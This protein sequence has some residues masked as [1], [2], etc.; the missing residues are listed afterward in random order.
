MARFSSF[1]KATRRHDLKFV[2]VKAK[3]Q[4]L[5]SAER[6]GVM[7]WRPA[8]EGSKPRKELVEHIPANGGVLARASGQ[9][10]SSCLNDV[11]LFGYYMIGSL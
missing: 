8:Y 10:H 9:T 1:V 5:R 2:L 6:M 4:S 7:W 3:T 11:Y